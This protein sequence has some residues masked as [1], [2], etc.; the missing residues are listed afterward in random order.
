[1]AIQSVGVCFEKSL[2]KDVPIDCLCRVMLVKYQRC[3]CTMEASEV[4]EQNLLYFKYCC[5]KTGFR[6]V[7]LFFSKCLLVDD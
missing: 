2:W 5:G 4:T 7:R 3:K 6:R 1:M